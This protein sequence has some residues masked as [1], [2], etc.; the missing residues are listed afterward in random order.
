[1]NT[2][3][4]TRWVVFWGL[5]LSALATVNLVYGVT[6]T[7]EAYVTYSLNNSNG[8]AL[9]DGSIVYIIGSSNTINDGFPAWGTNGNLGYFTQGDDIF[10]GTVFVDSALGAGTFYAGPFYF[11]SDI[12]KYLYIRVFDTNTTPDG[13][14]NWNVSDLQDATGFNPNFPF[15]AVD[16]APDASIATTNYSY[17]VVIPEPGTGQL[18]LFLAALVGG[19]KLGMRRGSHRRS[20]HGGGN[21]RMTE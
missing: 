8:V 1:V 7:L 12:V 21:R 16:F 6:V 11:D 9:A 4:Q 18:V 2:S 17:F 3:R 19:L 20:T 10:I 14:I 5:F 13:W 15:L